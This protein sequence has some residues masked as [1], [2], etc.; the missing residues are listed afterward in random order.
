MKKGW[1]AG[2]REKKKPLETGEQGAQR[3]SVDRLSSRLPL[4]VIRG[5]FTPGDLRVWY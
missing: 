4:V 3:S 2:E 5:H 1:E